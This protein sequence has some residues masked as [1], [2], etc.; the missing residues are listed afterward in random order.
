MPSIDIHDPAWYRALSLGERL[1]GFPSGSHGAISDRARKLLEAWRTIPPLDR[2]TYLDRHS[3]MM[4]TTTDELAALLDEPAEALRDRMAEVPPWLIRL[5][6]VWQEPAMPLP[7][8]SNLAGNPVSGFL[9]LV[10]PI[11]AAARNRLLERLDEMV[12]P[13]APLASAHGS[14][15]DMLFGPLVIQALDMISRTMVLELNIARLRGELTGETSAS[16]FASFV[17]LL[18]ER[19]SSYLR[20]YPVLARCVVTLV[21]SWIDAA[22]RFLWHLKEDW[23]AL[24][25]RFPI[26][27]GAVLSEVVV[28]A[29]DRHAGG[30]SVHLLTFDDGSR[31][32]YKPRPLGQTA[33]FQELLGKLDTLGHRPE[34]FTMTVLDS[35]DHGWTGFVARQDC[36]DLD[37]VDRYYRRV[38]G[39]LA[40]LHL[41][42]G[43]DIHF[44]NL[45]AHGEHPVAID[46]ETIFHPQ[47]DL[48]I[49]GH[50][51]RDLA[52]ALVAE[53]VLRVG[54]LPYSMDEEG[55]DISALAPVA[56][57]RAPDAVLGW[58]GMATDEMRATRQR[59]TMASGQHRPVLSDR[60]VDASSWADTIV[61]GFRETYRLMMTH[62]AELGRL[63]ETFRGVEVRAVLRPTRAYHLI[64]AESFHPDLLRDGLD[65]DRHLARLWTGLDENPSLIDALPLELADMAAGDIPLFST[66][67]ES[68][69][70]IGWRGERRTDFF[71]RCALE[72]VRD[73]LASLSEDD[74]VF[75]E[76][77]VRASLGTLALKRDDLDWPTYPRGDRV[78]VPDEHRLRVCLIEAAVRVGDRLAEL[79]I[80]RDDEVTWLAMAYTRDHWSVDAMMEDLYGGT[81]GLILF[82]AH[83]GAL[84]GERRFTEL[85][86]LALG[87]MTRRVERVRDE[88]TVPGLYQG[89]GGLVLVCSRLGALWNDEALCQRASDYAHLGAKYMDGDPDLDVIGGTAG[90]L[91]AVCDHASRDSNM[92]EPALRAGDH[93]LDKAM[94][95]GDGIAWLTRVS[96][97][98]P[99][100]GYSHGTAGISAALASLY[101]ATGARRFLDGALAAARYEHRAWREA[102]ARA[103]EGH[104]AGEAS[105]LATSWCHG[106]PGIGLARLEL[107]GHIDEPFLRED[108]ALAVTLT[109][110]DGFGR[111]HC[112]CH[113]DLGNLALLMRSDLPREDLHRQI[114][115]TLSSIERH[116]FLCGT[117]L[118]VESPGLMNG[119]AG[120]GYGLLRLAE[121]AEVPSILTVGG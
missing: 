108:V 87:S 90:Y 19:A 67:P 75:Q 59:M 5:A 25:E 13:D 3:A 28:G 56:G 92:L 80:R 10:E 99:L 51:D 109:V 39:L 58:Q 48:P 54:L 43:T 113:G 38:G 4:G 60:D 30:G 47:P 20:A 82:M 50:P 78:D 115:E 68:R 114:A 15:V 120:I 2:D 85:A 103:G 118:S 21:D 83:L 101:G 64:L 102:R 105:A 27:P 35:G 96:G 9:K 79:A 107:L 100:L 14:V 76:W 62:R 29:G 8:P 121:P 89:W 93:L 7:L 46:L 95:H 55:F 112:L 34:F 98:H 116:G 88:I 49:S 61:S 23:P 86:R 32:V 18:P 111:N 110:R 77:L 40:L 57:Q 106:A 26:E 119:L 52:G 41:L 53:S 70:L 65:R 42:D 71:P 11:L 6:E 12:E 22:Y 97:E 37:Q 74:L 33:R 63:I 31:L 44:E 81:S 84:S 117:P 69:D 66:Q 72:R 45:I 24:L 73:R 36:R 17:A 1:V 104:R 94:A 91:K 16:R